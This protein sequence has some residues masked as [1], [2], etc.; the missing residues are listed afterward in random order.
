VIMKKRN[1]GSVASAR[2]AKRWTQ[3]DLAQR[4]GCSE[5]QIAKIETGRAEP[6]NWL[7]EAIGR[8]LELKTW[9]VVA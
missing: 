9:E 5:S 8:E 1:I 7:K 2:Q 4:V 6:P 3:L